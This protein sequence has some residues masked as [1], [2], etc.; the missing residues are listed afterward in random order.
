MNLYA[1]YNAN[2]PAIKGIIIERKSKT[3]VCKKVEYD[4]QSKNMPKIPM[5]IPKNVLLSLFFAKYITLIDY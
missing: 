1:P 4:V 3:P 2:K 5:R